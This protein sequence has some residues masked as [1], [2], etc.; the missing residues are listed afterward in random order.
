M[1]E[2]YPMLSQLVAHTSTPRHVESPTH[3]TATPSVGAAVNKNPQTRTTA[4]FQILELVG[5]NYVPLSPIASTGQ[6]SLA[7]LQR[8]SSSGDSGCL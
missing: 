3:L 5:Q 1:A 7:S 2:N 8:A 4:G 6:P